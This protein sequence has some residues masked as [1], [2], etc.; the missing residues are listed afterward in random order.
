VALDAPVPE[1]AAPASAAFTLKPGI[2]LA[3]AWATCARGTNTIAAA[4]P[5]AC[6]N[7]D[8]AVEQRRHVSKCRACNGA[9]AAPSHRRARIATHAS[10]EPSSAITAAR[11]RTSSDSTA[12]GVVFSTDAISSYDSP[13][14]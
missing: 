10:S 5:A 7:R 13:L 11:A 9:S 14:Q 1:A 8:R 2:V 6:A 4:I 3:S 12:A